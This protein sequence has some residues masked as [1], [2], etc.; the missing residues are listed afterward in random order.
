MD[1]TLKELKEGGAVIY[2]I[3]CNGKFWKI[4]TNQGVYIFPVGEESSSD[5]E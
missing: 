4:F 2:S 1:K 5:K 3:T